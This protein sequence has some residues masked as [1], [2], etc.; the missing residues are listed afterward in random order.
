MKIFSTQRGFPA[1]K[2]H[3]HKVP[4]ILQYAHSIEGL[5]I[6]A[7]HNIFDS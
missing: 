4:C 5:M 3:F 7:R 1:E 6:N 2:L